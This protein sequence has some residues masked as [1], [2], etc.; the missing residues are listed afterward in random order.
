MPKAEEY[1]KKDIQLYE[2]TVTGNE[3]ISPGVF[4]ISYKR[5]H[6]F[7]PGQ[8][9][10]IGVDREKPPRIYSICSGNHEEDIR[11]LFNIKEDGYL[12]PNLLARIYSPCPKKLEQGPNCKFGPTNE[13]SPRRKFPINDLNPLSVPIPPKLRTGLRFPGRFP[14]I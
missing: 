7:I 8:V 2:K 5:K 13:K 12:T 9:V 14:R 6:E 1:Q 10:K 4:V 11:V 3:E